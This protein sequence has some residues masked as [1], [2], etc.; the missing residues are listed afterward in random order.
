LIQGRRAGELHGRLLSEATFLDPV[1]ARELVPN[2]R[3]SVLD[4]LMIETQPAPPTM[5][6]MHKRMGRVVRINAADFD[7]AQ[8]EK[9]E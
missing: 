5:R 8:H 7:P 3:R 4:P 9:V 2:K 6:V 1:R